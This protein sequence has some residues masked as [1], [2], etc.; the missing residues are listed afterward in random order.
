MLRMDGSTDEGR[1]YGPDLLRRPAPYSPPAHVC[2][3]GVWNGRHKFT[4]VGGGGDKVCAVPAHIIRGGV[5]WAPPHYAS[6][7]F[8][9][10]LR[11]LCVVRGW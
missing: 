9:M 8:V 11:C 3:P 1:A 7:D 4:R 6:H 5:S 10:T 2:T